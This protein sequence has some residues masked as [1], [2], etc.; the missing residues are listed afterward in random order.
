MTQRVR[1]KISCSGTQLDV[2]LLSCSFATGPER[3]AEI[4]RQVFQDT[5]FSKTL[6]FARQMLSRHE[7]GGFD[8]GKLR[9]LAMVKDTVLFDP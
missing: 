6:A 3:F 2:G 1:D 5:S 9:L 8:G 7:S 4:Y